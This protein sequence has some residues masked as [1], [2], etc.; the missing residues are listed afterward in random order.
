[1]CDTFKLKIAL[2]EKFIIHLIKPESH[3]SFHFHLKSVTHLHIVLINMLSGTVQY[4]AKHPMVLDLLAR[5]V[6]E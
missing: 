1:M 6:R 5:M 2:Q 3:I 4:N